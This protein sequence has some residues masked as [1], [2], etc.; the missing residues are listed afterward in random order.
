M[1]EQRGKERSRPRLRN[2]HLHISAGCGDDFR[3]VAVALGAATFGPLVAAGADFLG[4]FCL[5]QGLYPARINSANTDTGSA[6]VSASSWGSKAE[7]FW[8]IA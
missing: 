5:D 6:L 4:R 7:W 3:S 8:V 1:L 2:L